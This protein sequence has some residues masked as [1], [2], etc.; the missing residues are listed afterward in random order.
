MC[1]GW[2]EG[3]E[4]SYSWLHRRSGTPIEARRTLNA[5]GLVLFYGVGDTA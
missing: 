3:A 4:N 5:P 2:V 1:C